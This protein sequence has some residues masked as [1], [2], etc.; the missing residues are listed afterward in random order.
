MFD[1]DAGL[2][3]PPLGCSWKPRKRRDGTS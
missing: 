3:G 1:A 2:T